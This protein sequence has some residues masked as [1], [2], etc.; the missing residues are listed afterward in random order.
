MEYRDQTDDKVTTEAAEAIIKYGVGIKVRRVRSFSPE[1]AET[2]LP[3]SAL[4]SPLM[5]LVSKA[6]ATPLNLAPR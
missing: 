4:P 3:S 5:R 6:S 2:E 1:D